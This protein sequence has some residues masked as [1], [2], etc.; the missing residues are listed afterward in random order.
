VRGLVDLNSQN[1]EVT[2]VA[3]FLSCTHMMCFSVIGVSIF[4]FLK[5]A[6]FDGLLGAA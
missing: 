4:L 1:C 3:K 2:T 6:L 5:M